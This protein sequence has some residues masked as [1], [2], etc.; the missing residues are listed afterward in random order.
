MQ[1][2]SAISIVSLVLGLGLVLGAGSCGLAGEDTPR[3]IRIAVGPK[4]TICVQFQGDEMRLATSAEGLKDATPVKAKRDVWRSGRRQV[5]FPEVDL[6]LPPAA[7]ES[8]PLSL[9]ASLGWTSAGSRDGYVFGQLIVSRSDEKKVRWDY[10]QRVGMGIGL[11]PDAAPVVQAADPDNLSIE[12][13]TQQKGG[14]TASRDVGIALRVKGG[15]AQLDDIQQDGKSVEA[16][17]R[18]LDGAGKEVVSEKGP[19]SKF[20]FG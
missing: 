20:G 8:R 9:R 19:L 14:R 5:Q 11:E 6:P 15:Q 12:I 3:Y 13:V 18:V 7:P 2:S 16:H 4:H 10:R 1:R 17:L